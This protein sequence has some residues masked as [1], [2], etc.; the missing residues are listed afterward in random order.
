MEE[1]YHGDDVVL[2]QL[3]E[4]VTNPT[5]PTIETPSV[6]VV[7]KSNDWMRQAATM[8]DPRPLWKSLWHENEVCCLF[9]D[10]NVGKSIYAVQ[11]ASH[12][13]R[14]HKVMYFDFEL[15]EKQFQ[16]RYTDKDCNMLHSFPDKFYRCEINIREFENLSGEDILEHIRQSALKF[17]C[18]I[19]IIDNVTFLSSLLENGEQA[20]ELMMALCRMAREE[21][22]SILILAHTPKRQLSNPISQND[23][24]GSKKLFNFFNSAFALG[25]SNLGANFRYLKQLKSRNTELEYGA[26]NVIEYEVVKEGTFLFFK[27]LGTSKERK[28][29]R[30]RSN[31]PV[32]ENQIII[33][34]GNGLTQRQIATKLG[35]SIG[36]VNRVIQSAQNNPL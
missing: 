36:K 5:R 20:G 14:T 33:E 35:V 1:I 8:P 31:D 10:S 3:Q 29:L 15:S 2:Q 18:R 26:D 24:A 6:F 34:K 21:N 22:F 13:A 12:I 4:L 7:K 16:I 19:L 25:H 30:E 28:H 9:A 17:D 32:L 23:L 11:I 27:E